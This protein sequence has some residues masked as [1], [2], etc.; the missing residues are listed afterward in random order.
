M[1]KLI[2]IVYLLIPFISQSQIDYINQQ[3]QY[4][5]NNIKI[6]QRDSYYNGIVAKEEIWKLD[7]LGRIVYQEF[8]PDSLIPIPGK[9]FWNYNKNLL[10]SE[11]KIGT[12]TNKEKQDTATTL[13]Y[14]NDFQLLIKT[15]CTTTRN[16]DTL[17]ILYEY[18]QDFLIGDSIFIRNC[19]VEYST[20]SYELFDS[21][22]IKKETK[23]GY[24]GLDEIF[25]VFYKTEK[26]FDNF[27]NLLKESMFGLSQNHLDYVDTEYNYLFTYVNGKLIK[28]E[29]E[30]FSKDIEEPNEK[31]VI[32]FEYNEQGLVS[33]VLEIDEKGE[34]YLETY[35][36]K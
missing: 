12:W 3:E 1:K 31:Y 11:I 35:I 32:R 5:K 8:M 30:Y 4:V 22:N 28:I 2:F 21:N 15:Q 13:Y 20:Y 19:C 18:N 6:V 33:K 14:Y 27:G 36:Y 29:E 7:S 24:S 10:S 26:E 25:Y 23:T 9:T 34:E 16:N 17:I